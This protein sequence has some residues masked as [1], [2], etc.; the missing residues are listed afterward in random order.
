MFRGKEGRKEER[1]RKRGR[2]GPSMV[3]KL[4]HTLV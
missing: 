1:R 3:L 4:S 2:E